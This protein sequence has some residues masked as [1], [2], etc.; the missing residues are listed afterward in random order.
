LDA[1]GFRDRI[2]KT[3][4]T[5]PKQAPTLNTQNSKLELNDQREGRRD[6]QLLAHFTYGEAFILLGVYA[7]GLVSGL[8]LG[9]LRGYFR[10]PRSR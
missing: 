1:A 10:L 5:N 4:N 6:M 9:W 3:Q 7:L 8:A 2:S